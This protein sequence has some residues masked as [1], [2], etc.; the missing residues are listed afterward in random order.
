M[1]ASG[2]VAALT[3]IFFQDL[4]MYL[5]SRERGTGAWLLGPSSARVL[6]VSSGSRKG[7]EAE[8]T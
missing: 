7:N 3:L 2:G 4:L 5:K 6:A 8:G 1:F